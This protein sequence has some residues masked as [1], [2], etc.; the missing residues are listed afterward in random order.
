MNKL[1]QDKIVTLKHCYLAGISIEIAARKSDCSMRSAQTY[2][3]QFKRQ[4][5]SRKFLMRRWDLR[6]S[7]TYMGPDMMGKAI[8]AQ[9]KRKGQ[10]WIG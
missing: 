3:S 2:F 6:K 1:T 4:G 10:E 7:G 8:S 9:P 5:I